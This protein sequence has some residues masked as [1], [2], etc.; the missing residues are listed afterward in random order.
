MR[1]PTVGGVAHT[2]HALFFS[3]SILHFYAKLRIE[4]APALL[5]LDEVST[6]AILRERKTEWGRSK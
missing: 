4:S 3:C 1:A 2:P 5:I 6:L